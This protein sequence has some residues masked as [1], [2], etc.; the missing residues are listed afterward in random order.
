MNPKKLKVLCFGAGAIG[1]YVGGSLS[2]QGH[3][4]H[5]LDRPETI[6]NIKLNGIRLVIPAGTF[7]L[8]PVNL[9]S[10][11]EEAL[12][13]YP[14]DFSIVA[15]KSFDTASLVHSW[16]GRENFIPPVLCLQNG[17]E[18]EVLIRSI[19]GKENTISGSVTTAI[20]RISNG[21]VVERLRGIGVED[22]NNLTHEIISL[23]SN[24]GLQAIAYQDAR[25]MK[26][27]KLLT[28]LTTNASS[29][30]L[31]MTP[32]EIISNPDLFK[33]EIEQLRET[34]RVMQAQGIS[35]TNLP[36]TP[37]KLFA[38][39]VSKFPLSISKLILNKSISAGRGGKMPS[40]YLDLKSN[41][42]KSE[43]DYLNG[44]VVRF[45]KEVNVPAPVNEILTTTLMKLTNR[46]IPISEFEHKPEQYKELFPL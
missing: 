4:V 5:F 33:I 28:N 16:I 10:S 21:V 6:E 36:G 23:M 11:L 27:S 25:S 7:D 37:V 17:V 30:I 39:V 38:M 20:G 32:S 31:G 26:W 3:E 9:W 45:G 46:E 29:A 24:A 8:K 35:V 41:R 2:I 43:V 22:K 42:K 13:H 19:I 44:A 18:N 40:F 1:S 15:V 12:K 14:F 34:M